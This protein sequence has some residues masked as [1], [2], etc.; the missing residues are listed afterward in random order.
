[1]DWSEGNIYTK[2][3]DEALIDK[4]V[5]VARELRAQVQGEED[6]VYRSG[7]EPP[8]YRKFSVLDRLRIWARALYPAPR[9]IIK[10]VDAPFKVGDRVL[11]LFRRETTV[12][13]IDAHANHGLG[14]VKLRYNDG[15]EDSFALKASG[16]TTIPI[17][18]KETDQ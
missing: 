3:P 18:E 9:I 2:N 1:M 15:R 13:E 17:P 7:H 8:L 12:V 14:R 16:I 5:A 4:M 11:D 6:E 10:P